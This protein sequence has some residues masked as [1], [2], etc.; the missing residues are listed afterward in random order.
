MLPYQ[1]HLWQLFSFYSTYVI[2]LASSESFMKHGVELKKCETTLSAVF[3][4]RVLITLLEIGHGSNC[5]LQMKA[6]SLV[7]MTHLSSF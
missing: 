7:K 2:M 4:H 6:G 1:V 3:H 5:P